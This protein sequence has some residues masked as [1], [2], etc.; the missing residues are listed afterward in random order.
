MGILSKLSTWIV[1]IG[2]D[3]ISKEAIGNA[4]TAILDTIGVTLAGSMEESGKI[5]TEFIKKVGGEQVSTVIGQCLKTSPQN[6]ALAN[7]T[8]AHAL[9]FDDVSYTFCGHPSAPILPAVLATGEYVHASGLNIITAFIIGFEIACKIGMMTVPKIC[10]DGWHST[11]ILASFGATAAA[12]KLLNLNVS[13]MTAALAINASQTCGLKG[14]AGTMSKHLQ[15]GRAAENGVVAAI[16][17]K[18]GFTGVKNVFEGVD[19]FFQV[20]KVDIPNQTIQAITNKL[21]NP[22]DI[23]SPGFFIKQFP[24]C[25]EPQSAMF[26]LQSLKEEFQIIA[27]TVN[28][29]ECSATPMVNNILIYPFP[30][31]GMEGKFSMQFCLALVLIQGEISVSDFSDEKVKDPEV[32]DLMKRIK[33]QIDEEFANE[34][35]APTEHPSAA[36]VKVRMKNGDEYQKRANNPKWNPQNPPAMEELV[37]KYRNCAEGI[38]IEEKVIKSIELIKSMEKINDIGELMNLLTRHQ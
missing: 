28:S 11:G 37:K 4:K 2:P 9:D 29:I 13:Q 25:S 5:I 18:D 8:M 30:R 17:A 22:F 10:E 35:Y 16:L 32:I 15:A 6:A 12:G 31:T 27:E 26:A 19:G 33:L 34:G 1:D 23:V 7:G 38:L 21:G 14:N 20:L 36:I 3:D 24:C